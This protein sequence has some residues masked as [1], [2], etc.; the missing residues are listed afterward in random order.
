MVPDDPES[1][2]VRR[3]RDSDSMQEAL[4]AVT[5]ELDLRDLGE[6]MIGSE[7]VP[8]TIAAWIL[9]RLP[10]AD[11]VEVEMG[12]RRETGWARRTRR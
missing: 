1:G 11:T 10:G 12:W 4:D 5:A 3:V 7:T 2:G 6:M 8:E 9:E